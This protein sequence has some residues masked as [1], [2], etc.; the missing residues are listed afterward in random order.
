MLREKG[1]FDGT[2]KKFG[3]S[4]AIVTAVDVENLPPREIQALKAKYAMSFSACH[5]VIYINMIF[6]YYTTLFF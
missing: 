3:L 1:K 6:P 5:G 2:S 4:L